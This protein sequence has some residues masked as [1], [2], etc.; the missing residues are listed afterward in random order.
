MSKLDRLKEDIGLLKLFLAALI[1]IDV[2]LIAW[3]AQNYERA[4]R[5]LVL[6][7]VASTV[8]VTGASIWITWRLRRAIEQ[9][10]DL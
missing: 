7:G 10:E 9:L 5:L 6:G 1:V 3:V 2:S 8:V 4:H